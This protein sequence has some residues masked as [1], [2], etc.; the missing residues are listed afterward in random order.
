MFRRTKTLLLLAFGIALLAML[1]LAVGVSELELL[2]GISAPETEQADGGALG[3]VPP[4]VDE[5]FRTAFRIFAVIIVVGL[6]LMIVY[7]LLTPE[8]R[9][10]LLKALVPILLFG[11]F[12][13]IAMRASSNL[14][15]QAQPGGTVVAETATVTP[16]MQLVNATLAEA[17]DEVDLEAPP[18]VLWWTIVTLALILT[19]VMVGAVR[20]LMRYRTRQPSPLAE[21]ATQAEETVEAIRAGADLQDTVLLCYYRMSQTLQ[22][23][24]GI[25]RETAMT[26]REF[27]TY[28]ARSG[29]PGEPVQRL[30]RL[31][32]QVRYGAKAMEAE[33]E[34][35]A[36]SS[37]GA[38]VEYCRSAP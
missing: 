18:W 21:L 6:P 24:R 3:D 2:P 16:L 25:A 22:E 29:L 10:N 35:R 5:A 17:A 30:T 12:L 11:L 23:Q 15:E 32:E 37:L 28:L 14:E 31:F 9:K 1:A 33:D 4:E 19:L 20:F 13:Y 34:A 26:P 36:L 38:I 8:A 7:S 27:E